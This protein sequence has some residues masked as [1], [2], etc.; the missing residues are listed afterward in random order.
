MNKIK[1]KGFTLIELLV[2]ISIIALLS[3]I[4]LVSIKSAR[5]KAILTKTVS[6]MKSLHTAIELYK[7]QFGVYPGLSGMSYTDDFICQKGTGMCS[8][9]PKEDVAVFQNADLVNNK[10]LSKPIAAPTFEACDNGCSTK[11]YALYYWKTPTVIDSSATVMCGDQKVNNYVIFLYSNTKKISMPA[12]SLLIG[13]ST[14]NINA[15][16]YSGNI[17]PPYAYCIAG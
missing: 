5:E 6:E 9:G 16:P 14:Y 11:G 13:T 1:Q 17:T 2:V 10:L 4:V 15:N 7:N 12:A 3:S 8:F